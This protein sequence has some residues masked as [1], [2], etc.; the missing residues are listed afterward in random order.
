VSVIDLKTG[1]ASEL[2]GRADWE[3]LDGIVWT[4]WQTLLFAEEV[5]DSALPDPE[6]PNRPG[7]AWC[8]S[9]GSTRAIP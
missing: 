6:V 9:S 3:A 1:R 2:V 5:A 8:T 4:P 7:A